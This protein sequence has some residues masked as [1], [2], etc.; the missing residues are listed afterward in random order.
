[1]GPYANV[2]THG[3]MMGAL[4][5]GVTLQI[6]SDGVVEEIGG[7][8]DGTVVGATNA[9][10]TAPAQMAG[11]TAP[12]LMA[13]RTAP[14]QMAG[15]T[16]VAPASSRPQSP[17]GTSWRSMSSTFWPGIPAVI[18]CEACQSPSPLLESWTLC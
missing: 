8:G 17:S 9:A 12:A 3:Q 6:G 16:A 2:P 14:A 18:I 4:G 13:G 11:R 7:L 5:G 1:M 15:L 10:M